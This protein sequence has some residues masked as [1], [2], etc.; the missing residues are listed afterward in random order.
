MAIVSCRD[1]KIVVL[2]TEHYPVRR[3]PK[4]GLRQVDFAF[5]GNQI[6]GLK[7]NTLPGFLTFNALRLQSI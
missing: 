7:Q 5:D 4:R 2:G 3:T 6:R 1:A